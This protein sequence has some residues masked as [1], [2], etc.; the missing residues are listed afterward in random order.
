VMRSSSLLP[1]FLTQLCNKSWGGAWERGRG[2]LQV[3]N[4]VSRMLQ[5]HDSRP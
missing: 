2:M 1:H 5:L 4:Q 3:T